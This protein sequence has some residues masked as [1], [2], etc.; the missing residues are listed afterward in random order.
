MYQA[1]L[2][3]LKILFILLVLQRLDYKTSNDKSNRKIN[4]LSTVSQRFHLILNIFEFFH[5]M[6]D[7]EK[8]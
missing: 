4:T 2:H 5:Q 7:P 3:E 1:I 6:V 8:T